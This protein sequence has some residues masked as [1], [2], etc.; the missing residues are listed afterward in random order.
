MMKPLMLPGLLFIILLA[1]CNNGSEQKKGQQS[2]ADDT[3][4][5]PTPAPHEDSPAFRSDTI[6][7]DYKIT[8]LTR[9][10]A[11]MR[12]LLIGVAPKNDTTRTDTIIERDI[13]GIL[14][15]FAVADINKDHLPE[16][17]CFTTSSGT[18]SF[19]KV[20]AYGIRR[21][22]LVRINTEVLDTLQ[23]AGY[24]G[25]DSFYIK[26]NEFIRTFPAYREDS[27]EALTENAMKMVRYR[28]EKAGVGFRL[29]EAR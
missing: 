14:K 6:F 22:G 23:Q 1:A 7:G 8:V 16:L 18:G 19:G 10:D 3:T 15:G 2:L 26:G 4:R 24:N 20:Y 27:P 25:R 12:N 17:Y 28:L 11:T 13:K 9:G 29:V 21:E 5:A